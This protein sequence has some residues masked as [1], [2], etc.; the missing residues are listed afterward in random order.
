MAYLTHSSARIGRAPSPLTLAAAAARLVAT[1]ADVARERRALREMSRSRLDDLGLSD[2]DVK[3]E[4]QRPFFLT[5]R[6]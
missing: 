5:R 2:A 3:R 1:W 6:V 4:A